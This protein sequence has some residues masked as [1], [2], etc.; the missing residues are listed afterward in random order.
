MLAIHSHPKILNMHPKFEFSLCYPCF[1]LLTFN[2][3]DRSTS[4]LKSDIL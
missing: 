2:N 1:I 4:E 3:I